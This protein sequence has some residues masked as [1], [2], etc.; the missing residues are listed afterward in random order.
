[1]RANQDKSALRPTSSQR[2]EVVIQEEKLRLLILFQAAKSVRTQSTASKTST[3][4]STQKKTGEPA[5]EP[6]EE[7][8]EEDAVD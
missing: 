3:S 7:L 1:M 2:C 8:A 4:A 6:A 5:A